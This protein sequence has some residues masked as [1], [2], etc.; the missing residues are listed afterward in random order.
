MWPFLRR[1][2]DSFFKRHQ[3]SLNIEKLDQRVV[4][5]ANPAAVDHSETAVIQQQGNV[6]FVFGTERDDFVRVVMGTDEHFVSINGDRQTFA[7]SV[8]DEV[9]VAGMD[10]CEE[11]AV[12]GS[13]LDDTVEV[14]ANEVEL[15]SDNYTVRVRQSETV[16]V[17]GGQ[18]SNT[19]R[20]VDSAGDDELYLHPTNANFVNSNGDVF[21]LQ[22]MERVE[23]FAQNGGRDFVRF[24]DSMADDSFVAKPR[25]AYMIGDGFWNYAKGFERVDAVSRSGGR[26]SARLY[27][28]VGDDVLVAR[29]DEVV[30]DTG[31]VVM[32]TRDYFTT[33]AIADAGGNDLATF[34]GQTWV[35]DLFVW[36]ENSSYMYS[37]GEFDS[38]LPPNVDAADPTTSSNL[39][40]GFDHVEAFG[41]GPQDR[42]ELRGSAGNDRVIALPEVVQMTTPSADVEVWD[43]RIVRSHGRGG[44]DRAQLQDSDGNDTYISNSRFAYLEGSDF[45]NYVSGFA[46]DVFALNEGEDHAHAQD[47]TGPNRDYLIFDGDQFLIWGPNR[48]ERIHGFTTARGDGAGPAGFQLLGQINHAFT[49]GGAHDQT[50]IPSEAVSE[51][52]VERARE[53]FVLYEANK[54]SFDIVQVVDPQDLVI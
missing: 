16:R 42:A 47:Y 25:F 10:G 23:A 29:P 31:R 9:V 5:S 50:D 1:G 43:F 22:E 15:R 2:N 37:T 27:D 3:R 41:G 46:I 12:F 33:R 20:I 30:L 26:D 53:D 52:I 19:A 44:S 17:F 39:A 7:A 48:E 18:G 4:L 11:V 45:L 51:A 13:E 28:S 40:V 32:S 38:S 24:F 6:V 21:I 54:E 35:K 36:E 14:L 8:V 34:H 49:I